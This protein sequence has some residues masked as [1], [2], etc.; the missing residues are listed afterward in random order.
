MRFL[1][2]HTNTLPEGDLLQAKAHAI[3]DPTKDLVMPIDAT[4]NV[5]KGERF[6]EEKTCLLKTLNELLE[7]F[8]RNLLEKGPFLLSKK[9]TYCNFPL[10]HH[11]SILSLLTFFF[12]NILC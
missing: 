1:A 11:P 6:I 3:F 10:Y 8:E 2:K 12:W 4:I 5:R 7:L 9:V